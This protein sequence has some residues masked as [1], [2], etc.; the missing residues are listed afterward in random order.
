V[1]PSCSNPPTDVCLGKARALGAAVQGPTQF[2]NASALPAGAPLC[3]LARRAVLLDGVCRRFRRSRGPVRPILERGGRELL[4]Q[5]IIHQAG[6]HLFDRGCVGLQL[7]RVCFDFSSVILRLPGSRMLGVSFPK[8]VD[9]GEDA[10]FPIDSR[11]RALLPR[12][13]CLPATVGQR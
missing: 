3:A 6:I 5:G 2:L 12:G 10:Q 7:R 4:Q 8:T 11:G 13:P 1:R 9:K